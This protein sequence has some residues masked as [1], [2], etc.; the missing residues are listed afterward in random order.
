[1]Y[2]SVEVHSE[3]RRVHPLKLELIA[4]VSHPLWVLVTELV[5]YNLGSPVPQPYFLISIFIYCVCAG[6]M[7][8]GVSKEVRGQLQGVDSLLPLCGS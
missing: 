1:M 6:H 7:C 3:S 2:T 8:L 4:V 5:F